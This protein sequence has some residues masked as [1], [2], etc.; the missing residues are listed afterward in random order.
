MAV[1]QS[2]VDRPGGDGARCE[3][4][5][6]FRDDR[7]DNRDNHCD[8]SVYIIASITSPAP[9]S[10]AARQ[11]NVAAAPPL[12]I[13]MTALPLRRCLPPRC[14]RRRCPRPCCPPTRRG[15]RL[16]PGRVRHPARRNEQRS[17]GGPDADGYLAYSGRTGDGLRVSGRRTPGFAVGAAPA[18]A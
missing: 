10:T 6:A 17:T 12:S 8:N 9:T 3:R 15:L 14:L 16:R 1:E 11:T 2:A 7:R 4:A 18:G 5:S 13:S